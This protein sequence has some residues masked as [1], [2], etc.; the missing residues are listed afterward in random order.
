[1]KATN[2]TTERNAAIDAI[3]NGY[4]C[5]DETGRY[6]CSDC[7]AVFEKGEVYLLDGRYFEA[8]RAVRLHREREHSS[9]LEALLSS[10]SKYA[11]FTDHQKTLL[12]LMHDGLSDK[13]I[14]EQL[15]V[16]PSTVRH[17][18]FMFREKEKQA[19]MYLAVYEL[20]AEGRQPAED[21]L[22]PVHAGARMVDDRYIV[23]PPE[24][25]RILHN[26]FDS[27][28]PLRLTHF[29]PK[30]K[31][32]LV[33]LNRISEEFEAGREYSEKE[34]NGILGEIYDDYVTLRRYL[35]EYGFLNRTR[36]CSRYWVKN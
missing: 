5:D 14:A 13:E 32:K 7:G 19:R 18:K 2:Y 23:T 22:M 15:E 9:R 16:S 24:R 8:C 30:Q 11:A 20:A 10:D 35:I 28:A 21:E 25:D 33:I 1:M 3:K 17:Q 12:R 26:A 6:I 29:P 36:D 34:V 31:K 27:L 4:T